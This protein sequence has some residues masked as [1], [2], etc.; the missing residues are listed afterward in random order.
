MVAGFVPY[1]LANEEWHGLL[2]QDLTSQTL[3]GLSLIIIGAGITLYCIYKFATEG[4]GTLSPADPTKRLVVKGLYRYSRNPMYI[5]VMLMLVG[6]STASRSAT[7]WIYSLCVFTMFYLF[8]LLFEEPRLKKDFGDEYD[9]YCKKV[10][11]W[12]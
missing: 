7:L 8:I 1:W 11:R 2:S 12:L 6:E 9:A 5:G 10:A 4:K 3:I